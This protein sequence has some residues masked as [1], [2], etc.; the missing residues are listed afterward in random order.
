[1]SSVAVIDYG[2]GNL[3]SIAKA[4]QYTDANVNV[5]VSADPDIIL[6]RRPRGISR[7]RGNARLHAALHESGLAEIIKQAAAEKP[8]LGRLPRHAGPVKR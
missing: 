6:R 3:H 7:R 5:L 2:M 1:M 8:L 4:L